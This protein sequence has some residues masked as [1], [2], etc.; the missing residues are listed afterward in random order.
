[1]VATIE[2]AMES[3]MVFPSQLISAV[4][5]CNTLTSTALKIWKTSETP[6]QSYSG[7]FMLYLV[8]GG[9]RL[10]LHFHHFAIQIMEMQMK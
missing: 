8:N 4:P 9:C 6:R 3:F 1:M 5:F 2:S 7:T 10:S